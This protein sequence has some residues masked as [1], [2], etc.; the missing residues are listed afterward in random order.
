MDII[1]KLKKI[2]TK[3]QNVLINFED[4]KDKA[5][6][7][8]KNVKIYFVED[9]IVSIEFMILEHERKMFAEFYKTNMKT[10]SNEFNDSLVNVCNDLNSMKDDDDE[11]ISNI[12]DKMETEI[13][14]NNKL[15]SEYHFVNNLYA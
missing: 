11:Q 7:K 13:E 10:I 9:V 8:Y 6:D 2:K 3:L 15:I 5:L 14:R 4:T 1:E 12:I